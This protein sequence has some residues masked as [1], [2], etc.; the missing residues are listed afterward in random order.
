MK[1]FL[2][3][4]DVFLLRFCCLE[5]SSNN[6]VQSD[7]GKLTLNIDGCLSD[8]FSVIQVLLIKPPPPPPSVAGYIYTLSTGV[9]V[10]RDWLLFY[11]FGDNCWNST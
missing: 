11:S 2:D 3:T 6:N 10:S 8:N 9:H 7:R 4:I 1:H 5:A